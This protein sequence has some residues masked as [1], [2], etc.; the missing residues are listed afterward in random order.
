MNT[1]RGLFIVLE[2]GDGSGKSTQARLLAETL[3]GRGI[4][5][6]LTQEPAGTRLGELVKGVFE[7]SHSEAGAP[8]ISAKTEL[9]LFEAARS[10]HVRTVIRPALAEGRVVV[11]DRFG[12]STLAYQGYGRGLPL[13]DI[14]RLN[15]IATE[16]L[17]PDLVIVA[18]VT[19]EVGTG[20]A[21]ASGGKNRDSIGQESLGFH[22]RGRD[23]F[24]EI[25]RAGGHRY[26]V[27]DAGRPPE[28]VAADVL[29]AVERVLGEREREARL[30][31]P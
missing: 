28:Q 2:G 9:F 17:T 22:R 21:D 16:G 6:V 7:R 20:R 1:K 8:P 29:R 3:R 5:V 12:D 4:N 15:D 24:R 26:V 30:N 27:V 11:C 25:A 23:G 31:A 19:P 14:R 13:D 18:D 10:D